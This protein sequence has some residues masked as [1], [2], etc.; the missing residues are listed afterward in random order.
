[1]DVTGVTTATEYYGYDMIISPKCRLVS[2]CST[3]KLLSFVLQREVRQLPGVAASQLFTCGC[4]LAEIG[5]AEDFCDFPTELTSTDFN[6]SILSHT[7]PQQRDV[8]SKFEKNYW[9]NIFHV[10]QVDSAVDC[11]QR[12]DFSDVSFQMPSALPW[13]KWIYQYVTVCISFF[14]ALQSFAIPLGF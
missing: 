4:A 7:F 8:K 14:L 1:M 6:F 12:G 2:T 5:R 9:K 13:N 3:A 11:P 10:L